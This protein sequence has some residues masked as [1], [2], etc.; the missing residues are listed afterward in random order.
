[1]SDDINRY[2]VH[3]RRRRP[4]NSGDRFGSV[5]E[6]DRSVLLTTSLSDADY[7]PQD[8]LYTIDFPDDH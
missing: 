2:R 7:P 8:N 4:L 3:A 1:M 5:S 6:L